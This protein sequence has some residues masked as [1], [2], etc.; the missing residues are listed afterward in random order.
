MICAS[1]YLLVFIRNLLVHL[2]EK[3]LLMQPLLSGGITVQRAS[4]SFWDRF[5]GLSAQSPGTS[6]ALIAVC[7]ARVLWLRGTGTIDASRICP[8]RAI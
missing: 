8:P 2:A 1:V 3:I 4:T 6:P 5:A 7:S